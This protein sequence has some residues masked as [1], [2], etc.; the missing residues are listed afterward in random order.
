MLRDEFVL[1]WQS[2]RPVPKVT[3]DFGDGR[4]LERTLT[5]NSIHYVLDSDGRPIDALPG[6]YGPQAFL[7]GLENARSV[8]FA[9]KDLSEPD[10]ANYLVRLSHADGQSN[11]LAMAKRS[12]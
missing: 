9:V 2:V 6:L 3:I 11:P 12:A 8:V 1:H 5:G 4:K 10:R 7:R